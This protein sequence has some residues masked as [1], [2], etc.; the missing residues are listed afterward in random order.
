[1][2]IAALLPE[3]TEESY[4]ED[5]DNEGD[6]EILSLMKGYKKIENQR[7]RDAFCSFLF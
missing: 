6:N 3:S 2:N 7:L 1:V 5:E 4:C